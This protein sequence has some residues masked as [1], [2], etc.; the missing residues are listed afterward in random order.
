MRLNAATLRNLEIL[1]NQVDAHLTCQL[2]TTNR[3]I[4]RG[5]TCPGDQ[6]G[7][8]FIINPPISSCYLLNGNNVHLACL[9]FSIFN[10]APQTLSGFNKS[11]CK[12]LT[13]RRRREGKPAV[14]AGP[15]SHSFREETAEEVGGPAPH[16][17]RVSTQLMK[18]CSPVGFMT[19]VTWHKCRI[20]PRRD[21][22]LQWDI[23]ELR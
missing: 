21:G 4:N 8:P 18:T 5:Q 13:D 22:F 17:L 15:H 10:D 14:G 11:G 7:S 9:A 12:S 1:N 2:T 20:A 23:K 3:Q 19:T 6:W 16:R